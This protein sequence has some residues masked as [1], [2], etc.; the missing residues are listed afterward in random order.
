MSILVVDI[1]TSSLRAAIVQPDGSMAHEHRRA[2]PPDT[3]FPGLI[4]FDAA[5]MGALAVE[6]A[7]AALRDG[8]PV[9]AVGIANQRSSTVVWDRA[10]G[11]PIGP[12]L[13]W[14]DLRTVFDCITLAGEGIKVAPNQSLTK[15]MWLLSQFDA[16]RSRDLCFGTVDTWI[17]WVLSRGQ[18]HVT[19]RSNAPLTGM[20]ATDGPHWSTAV[21]DQCKIPANMMPRIVDSSGVIGEASALVGSPVIA[22]LAGDQQASLL[23]QGCVHKGMAKITF[24]TGG[25][26][27]LC[28]DET[29]PSVHARGP[30]GTFPIVA[31]S[32][33]GHATW[34]VEAI[35]LSAGTN[36]D[37]LRE[38]L[39]LIATAAESHDVA[40]RCTDTGGVM[41]VP[42]LFGLG[43]PSWDY[44]ARGTLLGLSRGS[45]R[46]E[47]VRAVLE[48]VA[49]RGADLLD[50]A[51]ADTGVTVAS[52]R[53][54]GGMS[55]NPTFIQALADATQ[56]PVEVSP[57]TEATAL[58]AAFL[59][60]LAVGT[61]SGLD[62]LAATWRPAVTVAPSG[63]LDRARWA[64]AVDRSR[65]WIPDLSALDF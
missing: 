57:V 49:Q 65:R 1:G 19:D 59:A 43:T 26:L 42:A 31:W 58:G 64:E 62:D 63:M 11:E 18:L 16:D 52:L 6:V 47:V 25:M 30:H 17:A 41:Y 44:G 21:L 40:Q 12:G 2:L 22:G 36:V 10:T 48:G 38:D 33:N 8:G 46:A 20:L 14:Q 23:G 3:P 55:Q 28:L 45:G 54:D 39:G 4:E 29:E 7:A 24:G 61:W 35:M 34:G 50:A 27:D 37:W 32:R 15:V 13:G 60:G 53:V 9:A 51:E 56:R 5:R